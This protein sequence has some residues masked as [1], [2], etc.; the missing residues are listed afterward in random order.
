MNVRLLVTLECE[1][2]CAKCC[3][4]PGRG[5]RPKMVTSRELADANMILLTGGEPLL[6]PVHLLTT[7]HM[8][9]SLTNAKLIVYTAA[10]NQGMLL[11]QVIEAADGITLTLHSQADADLFATWSRVYKPPRGKSLRLN[12]FKGIKYTA[13]KGWIV[14]DNMVWANKCTLPKNEIYRRYPKLWT[15]ADNPFKVVRWT[16]MGSWVKYGDQGYTTKHRKLVIKG[17]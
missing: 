10:I 2:T 7:I 5:P 3:N 4:R 14:Q 16:A 9:R 6:F 13:P 8:L 15:A 12:V 17:K 1:R 11:T